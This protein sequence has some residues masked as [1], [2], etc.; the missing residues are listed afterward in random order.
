MKIEFTGAT[1]QKLAGKLDL[2]SGKPLAYALWAHC[3]SC[4][5]DVLA[6]SRVSEGLTSKG[7]AVLRFDFTGLGSSEGDFANTNFSS[8]VEDL[9]AAADHLRAHFEAPQILIGHSWGGTAIL[10]AAAH[11]PEARAVC[12]IAA[13]ADPA[14]VTKLFQTSL[15]LIED[16]GEAEV[17]L[18]GRPF[19]IKKQFLDDVAGRLLEQKISKLGKALLVLHSPTDNL[20]GIDEARAIFEAAKHP[21]SFVS[22]DGA[23]HLLS[24]RE[25]AEY[26]ASMIATW[27]ARYTASKQPAVPAENE[28]NAVVVS[29]TGSGKFANAI[30]FGG[31]HTM[32]ADE[33]EAYGG[34]DTGPS[35][36]ELLLAALGAC[37]SMT[38][39]MYAARKGFALDQA[40]V[41]LRHSKV[42][43]VDCDGCETNGKKVDRI[44]VDIEVTGDL[45]E[46]DRQKIIAIAE[47]CPVHRTLVSNVVI[48]SKHKTE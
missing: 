3:F 47:K 30:S 14:H 45:N 21:K 28:A 20:V 31:R 6:A 26:V 13:P 42:H 10:A 40:K 18:A 5:K 9:V 37:K 19:R 41:T 17:L 2:P 22:L 44:E 16:Q 12:T 39:R 25:D 34:S 36:Y 4:T 38:M 35:P 29:E 11:V 32:L 24:R 8:N 23:D 46:E 43:A 1:G 33:P 15:D 7:I 48:E 27:A